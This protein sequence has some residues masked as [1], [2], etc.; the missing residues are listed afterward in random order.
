M[1]KAVLLLLTICLICCAR[2]INMPPGYELVN[3]EGVAIFSIT[4]AGD[5]GVPYFGEIRNIDTGKKY[6]INLSSAD[7]NNDWF[8]NANDCARKPESYYG[9]VAVLALP[10]GRYEVY[11][12]EG[13][14]DSRKVYIN[15]DIS[16]KFRILENTNNYVGNF[17]FD[18]V[19]RDIRIR[20]KNMSDRDLKVFQRKYV[21]F[22]GL[23]TVMFDE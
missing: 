1:K 21:K 8:K 22:S 2:V 23:K 9:R 18:I 6:S 13:I 5:C 15:Q 10:A 20:H 7:K 17:H 3:D 14:N 19:R 11:Q 4:A 16:I 12:F